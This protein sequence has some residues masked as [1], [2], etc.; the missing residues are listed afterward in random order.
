M[1]KA[2]KKSVK[3]KHPPKFYQVVPTENLPQRSYRQTDKQ[4]N[5]SQNSGRPKKKLNR[6]RAQISAKTIKRQQ[7]HRHE[8]VCEKEDFVEFYVVHLSV[9][10]CPLSVVF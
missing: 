10:S 5:Q 6:I 3:P 8:C 1:K 7:R 4:K 9:V 2:V